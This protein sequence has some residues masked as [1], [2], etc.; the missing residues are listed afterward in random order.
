MRVPAQVISGGH[1]DVDCY[2]EDPNG[3][4]IYQETKKQYD[5]FTHHT[6]LKGVYT[7]CF[8]NEF[9]TFSHKIVYFDFQVGDEP[10]ILP[11]MNNRVTALTQVGPGREGGRE[12][13]SC[14]SPKQPCR[15]A[16]GALSPS[17]STGCRSA[18][19]QPTAPAQPTPHP[20]PGWGGC[21]GSGLPPLQQLCPS[22]VRELHQ[23]FH[24]LL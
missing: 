12:G 14:C 8:G 20:L 23:P 6:E 11:D 9:S 21:A 17:S 1:Y 10:P 24:P 19:R 15:M 22:H 5:S 16:V 4:T 13:G 2:V 18:N 3:K 7:F